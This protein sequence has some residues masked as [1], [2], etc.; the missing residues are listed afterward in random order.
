MSLVS[1]IMATKDRP[2]YL[3]QAIRNYQQQTYSRSELIVVDDSKVSCESLIPKDRRIQYV[4]LERETPLGEKLNIGI[5]ASSGELIQKL[6]DDDY[7]SP[8]FLALAASTLLQ[9]TN[10][11]TIV[12]MGT[13]LVLIVGSPM[14]YCAGDDWFAGGTLCFFRDAWEKKG[15]RCIPSRVDVTFLE[16]HPYL[17][18]APISNPE[19]YI[20][21]RHGGNTWKTMRPRDTA[22]ESEQLQRID[23]TKHFSNCEPY[24]KTISEVIPE[25]EV[26]FY[27]QLQEA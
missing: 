4:R 14:L 9:R 6:D 10:N 13:F 17:E 20:L 25:G 22:A 26:G 11:D 16:D 19:L 15:F 24:D 5:R 21:V 2:Q 1:C 8:R 12:A 3:R 27:R 7:Y 18:R 23:V